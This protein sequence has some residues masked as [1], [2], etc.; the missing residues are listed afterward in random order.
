MDA[1][2]LGANRRAMGSDGTQRG[3]KKSLKSAVSVWCGS[4]SELRL[5]VLI[6]GRLFSG[7]PH[8]HL[9]GARNQD[10]FCPRLSATPPIGRR[11]RSGS[12]EAGEKDAAMRWRTARQQGRYLRAGRQR[13]A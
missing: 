7:V 10:V 3:A 4:R 13:A 6:A 1:A 9:L 2:T 11:P 5:V 8:A 12:E